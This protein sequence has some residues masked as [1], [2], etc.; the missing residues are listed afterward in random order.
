MHDTF[1]CPE[2]EHISVW[3]EAYSIPTQ[4]CIL[5]LLVESEV[6][7][8]SSGGLVEHSV[9][10]QLTMDLKPHWILRLKHLLC[11][12]N[13]QLIR[14]RVWVQYLPITEH[15]V[16]L[17]VHWASKEMH[18]MHTLTCTL[19]TISKSNRNVSGRAGT[20]FVRHL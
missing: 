15:W 20:I 6:Q 11:F 9:K 7:V 18:T 5:L 17:R 8:I 2:V 14:I 16:P 19:K 4:V 12:K 13:M 3:S 1:F 10:F